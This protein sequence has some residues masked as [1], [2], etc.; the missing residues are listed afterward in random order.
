MTCRQGF[1]ESLG[2]R[3]GFSLWIFPI[4]VPPFDTELRSYSG[5]ALHLRDR[6][7]GGRTLR[8]G[9]SGGPWAS[10]TTSCK[11]CTTV[12]ESAASSGIP[13]QLQRIPG[14]NPK[15]V[16]HEEGSLSALNQ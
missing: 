10:R 9:S 13:L 8:P 11:P 7:R 6:S 4:P 1:G 3:F 14:R 16:A 12:T 5:Q 2:G 15:G